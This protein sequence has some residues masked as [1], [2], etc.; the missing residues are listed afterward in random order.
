MPQ[1]IAGESGFE[2]LQFEKT[3]AAAAADDDDPV[4]QVNLDA[5]L[6]SRQ[7]FRINLS[8]SKPGN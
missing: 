8:F 6:E 5:H 7:T 4:N 2:R 1:C 3:N